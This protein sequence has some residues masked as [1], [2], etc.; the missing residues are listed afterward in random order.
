MNQTLRR[1][2]RRQENRIKLVATVI[3][4]AIMITFVW[5]IL[6]SSSDIQG[7]LDVV[8][9]G[10]VLVTVHT[11]DTLWSIAKSYMNE[12]YYTFEKFVEEVIAMNSIDPHEI[13]AGDQLLIPVVASI[14]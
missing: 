14:D 11:D 9:K 4:L 7:E 8:D 13:Y 6:L 1:R 2:R 10:Y 5:N 12:D 3:L